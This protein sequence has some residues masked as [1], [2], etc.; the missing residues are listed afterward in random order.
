M[1]SN[2][3]NLTPG[4]SS[5]TEF[6]KGRDRKVEKTGRIGAVRELTMR[7]RKKVVSD[8]TPRAN[9]KPKQMKKKKAQK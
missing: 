6:K 9:E 2:R 8:A 1:T 5:K 7:R 3:S 4:R